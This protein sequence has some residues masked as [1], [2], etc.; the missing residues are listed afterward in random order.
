MVGH[1]S[2]LLFV[3]VAAYQVLDVLAVGFHVSLLSSLSPAILNPIS[4]DSGE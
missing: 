2:F 4:R 3:P 1:L